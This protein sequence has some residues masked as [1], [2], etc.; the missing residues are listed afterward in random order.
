M[1]GA[2]TYAALRNFADSW[3]LAAMLVFFVMACAWPF[4]P[5][6]RKAGQEAANMIF[7]DDENGQ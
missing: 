3:G 6:G 5:G 1:N 2:E 7:K 4:R